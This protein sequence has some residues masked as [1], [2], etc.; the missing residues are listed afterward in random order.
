ME[1]SE[2]YLKDLRNHFTD[3]YELGREDERARIATVIDLDLLIPENIKGRISD[4]IRGGTN[5]ES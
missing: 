3:G 4:L 1:L 2:G 5:Y